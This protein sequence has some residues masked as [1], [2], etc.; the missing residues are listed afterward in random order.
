MN[1]NKQKGFVLVATIWMTLILLVLAALFSS[2]AY[3]RFDAAVASKQRIQEEIDRLS[4]EQTLLFL[5]AT[6]VTSR[7]GLSTNIEQNEFIP[8]DGK[9]NRGWGDVRF[10][11]IDQGGLVGLNSLN[12]YHLDQLL[13][14][15][16]SDPLVR[17]SLLQALYDYIDINE[18]PRL[19]G[20]E[21]AAYR[22]AGLGAPS[23]NYL[24]SPQEL[25]NV[26]R[27]SDWLA[28]HPEFDLDWLSINWRSRLNLN[29]APD[30]VLRR[31]L[32]VSPIDRELLIST[33]HEG[34]FK[35][36]TQIQKLL[37][38][39]G[40]LD[41]DVYTLL[42]MNRI[43]I[44]I[45]SDTNARLSTINTSI[46]PLSLTAPWV[47]DSRYDKERNFNAR[48]SARTVASAFFGG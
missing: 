45:Y 12:N 14:A 41:E 1:A 26:L 22:V 47:V 48:G 5:F 39:R 32:P 2:Y 36:F 37:N 17:N 10:E 27:W 46:T 21:A 3:T 8:L 18:S 33:R 31:A 38:M 43:R 23:N 44:R 42:P 4:T 13:K 15:H 16:E 30:Q 40:E 7:S 35:D 34:P 20:G 6:G 28:D 11:V 9:P 19:S 29:T 25:R 24:K